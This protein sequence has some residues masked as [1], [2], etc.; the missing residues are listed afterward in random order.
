MLA[1][2]D[3]DRMDRLPDI[4]DGPSEIVVQRSHRNPYDHLV[5]A[6]GAQ[7]VEFGN[8]SGATAEAM[9]ARIGPATAGAF[10]HGQAEGDGLPIAD[11]VRTAHD[12]GLPVLV[13]ASM[14]LPPREN[15]RR[16]IDAGADLV[17]FS[18]GKTI[19]GPQASGFLAGRRDL[20]VSVG[21]QQQDMDVLPA[22]WARR[23]LLE[24]KALS[25]PPQHGIGRSMKTG[26][27]EIV[28]LLVALR[29]YADR[30]EAAERRR[31]QELT[32]RLA[33][34][35]SAIP[36]L[37]ARTEPAQADG[38]PVPMTVVRVDA[39]R[40]GATAV[41][42]VNALATRDPIVML[43]D[44]EA[45]AGILR[46]DPENLDNAGVSMVV[47]AFRETARSSRPDPLPQGSAVAHDQVAS[48]DHVADP[49]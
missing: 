1:R 42:A 8:A 32:D 39:D 40:F 38:R 44:H 23:S 35:L 27:E 7:L 5:R 2:L 12:H 20:L 36:G 34:E 37:T 49:S 16:F 25:R 43:A 31:W 48:G 45:E 13:D 26:K 30:D 14:N 17:A 22:T 47:A 6:S 11:F 21:L 28:G 9:A 15:L 10:F 18:G 33:T 46:L 19:G 24:D 29:R 41:Q 4:G 3:P